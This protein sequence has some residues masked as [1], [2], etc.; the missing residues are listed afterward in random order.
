VVPLLRC[1]ALR[2]V[3]AEG[4]RNTL[5]NQDAANLARALSRYLPPLPMGAG[6][7]GATA[8][9]PPRWFAVDVGANSGQTSLA[10][11]NAFT[12]WPCRRAALDGGLAVPPSC[13]DGMGEVA[14]VLAVEP[15]PPT[16]A[17]L[18]AQGAALHW[19]DVGWAAHRYALSDAADPAGVLFGAAEAGNEQPSLGQAAAVAPPDGSGSNGTAVEVLTLPMLLERHLAGWPT[20]PSLRAFLLKIDA[21]GFDPR[22]LCGAADVLR[23]QPAVVKFLLFE[24]NW[25]WA[26]VPRAPAADCPGN[27]LA[28]VVA[29]LG[30]QEQGLEGATGVTGGYTCALLT[31]DLLIPL[32]GPG[33][34]AAGYEATPLANVLCAPAGDADWAHLMRAHSRLGRLLVD[35]PELAAAVAGSCGATGGGDVAVT[36][37]AAAPQAPPLQSL[38]QGGAAAADQLWSRHLDCLGA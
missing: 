6:A 33:A 25:K 17:A 35:D 36:A 34:G 29:W 30:G 3:A 27:T 23:R 24:F 37:A 22:V 26:T 8:P 13:G 16:F 11:L 38:L 21:E 18:H 7:G 15:M 2:Y 32:S 10:M 12:S 1:L 5:Y 31:R 20:D 9:P 14:S 28:E 4:A 19:P